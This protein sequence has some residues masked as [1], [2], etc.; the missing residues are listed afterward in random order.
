[1]PGAVG[2]RPGAVGARPGAVVAGGMP[3]AAGSVA[4]AVGNAPVV[5]AVTAGEPAAGGG[6]GVVWPNEVSA[7]VTEHKEAV[8]SV[9]IY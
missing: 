7:K 8:S 5:G 2:A 3:V 6:G 4:G 9:F 1:M